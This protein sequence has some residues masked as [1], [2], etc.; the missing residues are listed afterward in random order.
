MFQNNKPGERR[1][2][3]IVL[4]IFLAVTL[5]FYV[6]TELNPDIDLDYTGIPVVF[7]GENNIL[8]AKDLMISSGKNATVNL[9]L[10]GKRNVL[11][12]LKNSQI[13]VTADV[14]Q[15]ASPGDYTLPFKVTFPTATGITVAHQ[16]RDTINITVS[17]MAIKTVPVVGIFNG[18]VAEGFLAED[19]LFYP[20]TIEVSGIV[21]QIDQVSHALVTLAG[22]KVSKTIEEDAPYELIDYNGNVL[23]SDGIKADLPAVHVKLPIVTTA[24]IPLTVEFLDG[25]GATVDNVTYTISPKS[26]LVSGEPE[27]LSS[28]KTIVLGT[29][30]LSEVFNAESYTFTIPLS[31]GLVNQSG[32]HEAVVSVS[33]HGLAS[34]TLVASNIE[35][36]NVPDGYQAVPVTQSLP[37]TVRGS[38]EA[39][40][41]VYEYNIRI[42]AD[43]SEI[44]EATGNYTLPAKV[45]LD[46]YGG[47]GIVGEYKVVV[48]ISK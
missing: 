15:I 9:K 40:A 21:E 28:L 48:S 1:I 18:S 13:Q 46:G 10:R 43:L 36:I 41:M 3:Y 30:D 16:S 12:N 42:V 45:Y 23:E 29:I 47:A 8:N 26:I 17:K 24:D 37:V 7:Q 6:V 34:K 22:T 32:I 20:D 14:S 31:N 33:I 5:W 44:R 39:I 38:E 11:L 27:E 19:F 2:M 35:V 4:S 25:G